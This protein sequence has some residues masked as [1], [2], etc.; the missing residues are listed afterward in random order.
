M[1][2][3]DTTSDKPAF[4]RFHGALYA[5]QPSETG[6]TFPTDAQLIEIARQAGVDG[7]VGVDMKLAKPQVSA[8]LS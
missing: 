1:A 3:A 5:Q 2:D 8:R 4:R 7:T 6:A